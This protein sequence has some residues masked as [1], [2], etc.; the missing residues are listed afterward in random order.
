[1]ADHSIENIKLAVNRTVAAAPAFND[2]QR[3]RISAAFGGSPASQSIV[4]PSIEA[5]AIAA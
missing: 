3:A 5:S 4:H 2:E 1:M